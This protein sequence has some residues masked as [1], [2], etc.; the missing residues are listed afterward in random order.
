MKLV[1]SDLAYDHIRK[2]I[3]SGAYAPGMSL[4][5]EELSSRIGVS[6]TPVRDALRQLETEGLVSIRPRLGATV[7]QMNVR[8]Y[9][10]TCELRLALESHAAGLAA[11]HRT[12]A[13]LHQ[14]RVALD[15]MLR[16][17]RPAPRGADAAKIHGQLVRADVRFHLAV[18]AAAHN[19]LMRREIMR[20]HLVSRIVAGP[21]P[22]DPAGGRPV[23]DDEIEHRT[24]VQ[25]CHEQIYD[26]IAR[27]NPLAARRAM[28]AHIQDIIDRSVHRLL[29]S[30]AASQPKELSEEEA[31]YVA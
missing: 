14:M 23:D 6:R 7:K 4:M 3:L 8:E 20:L 17:I 9:R 5:T 1:N 31:S 12:T 13:D 18:I 11:R 21:S 28:E 16:L 26:A 27:E 29:Q 15:E 30:G 24:A 25:K 19:E 2:R 10:E 22:G